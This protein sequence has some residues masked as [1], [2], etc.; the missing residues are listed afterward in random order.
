MNEFKLKL[1]D[2]EGPLDLLLHLVKEDK[3]DIFNLNLSS[4]CDQYIAFLKSLD[5]V[6][7]EGS[8]YLVMASEL[9]LIKSL[10]MFPKEEIPQEEK[11]FVRDLLEFKKYKEAAEL[12]QEN[13]KKRQA[14]FSREA[15]YQEY[16]NSR[17]VLDITINDLKKAFS[18]M[19]KENEPKIV[20]KK[21]KISITSRISYLRKILEAKEEVEF[22]DLFEE[23]SKPFVIATFLALLEMTSQKEIIIYQDGLYGKIYLKRAN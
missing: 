7:D 6:L 20:L 5:E 4:L 1:C 3:Q 16:D 23:Y 10:K 14:M 11:D 2:F 19:L 17:V 15:I 18:S 22:K 9:L 12:L 21:E 8:D 13:L